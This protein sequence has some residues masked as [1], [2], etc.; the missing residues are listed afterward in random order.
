MR[1]RYIDGDFGICP[2]CKSNV[3]PIGL[4]VQLNHS[5]VKVYCDSC[6]DVYVPIGQRSPFTKRCKAL[7]DGAYFGGPSFPHILLMNSPVVSIEKKEMKTFEPKIW[8]FKVKTQAEVSIESSL[9]S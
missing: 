4:S 1:Q 5:K 6:K 7:V 8:G 3:L 9:D 2:C